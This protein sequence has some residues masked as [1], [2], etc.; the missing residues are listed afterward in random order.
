[1]DTGV[2]RVLDTWSHAPKMVI[3]V[4]PGWGGAGGVPAPAQP[5]VSPSGPARSARRG[6][7]PRART[8]PQPPKALHAVEH[9]LY[10]RVT[11]TGVK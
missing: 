3:A 8:T 5:G 11:L 4:L 10:V 9:A 6:E 7:G 2:C 1:M